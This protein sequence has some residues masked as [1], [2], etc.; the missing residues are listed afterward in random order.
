MRG[1]GG[2]KA[3]SLAGRGSRCRGEP[4]DGDPLRWRRGL[5]VPPWNGRGVF[6]LRGRPF[7]GSGPVGS[8]CLCLQDAG[9]IISASPPPSLTLPLPPPTNFAVCFPRAYGLSLL[10]HRFPGR[11]SRLSVR[12]PSSSSQ[13]MTEARPPLYRVSLACPGGIFPGIPK[14]KPQAIDDTHETSLEG[15]RM[16]PARLVWP[17]S[18]HPS[19]HPKTWRRLPLDQHPPHLAANSP[20]AVTLSSPPSFVP[21]IFCWPL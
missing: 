7:C 1:E 20:L 14:A 15:V 16:T 19:A 8:V 3:F 18:S 6:W 5:V 4:R 10:M 21:W 17:P 12:E 2:L 11:I 13:D 9:K